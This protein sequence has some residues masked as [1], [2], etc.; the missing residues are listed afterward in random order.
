MGIAEDIWVL[1]GYEDIAAYCWS[2]LCNNQS[3]YRHA[4]FTWCST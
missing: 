4:V 2:S 3:H 1:L